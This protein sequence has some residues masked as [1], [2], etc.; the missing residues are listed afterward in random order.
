MAE[1]W[2]LSNRAGAMPASPIRRLAPLAVAA[3]R[4]GKHVHALNIGQPDIPTPPEMLDRLRHYD[5]AN[6]AYGP[7][8]GTPQF[9]EALRRYYQGWDLELSVEEIFVTSV[10]CG[11]TSRER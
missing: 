4:A 2:K 10:R 3:T 5:Q 6:V 7:S 8:E 11:R 1:S 9:R